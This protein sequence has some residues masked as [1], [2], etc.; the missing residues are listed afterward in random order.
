MHDHGGTVP[1]TVNHLLMPDLYYCKV[2]RSIVPR[3]KFEAAEVN[4]NSVDRNSYFIYIIM[5]LKHVVLG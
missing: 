1:S 4:V 2:C 5:P 3:Q